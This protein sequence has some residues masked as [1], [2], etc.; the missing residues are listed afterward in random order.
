ML[1]PP[2]ATRA[3]LSAL[4]ALTA[5]ARAPPAA[6]AGVGAARTHKRLAF[7]FLQFLAVVATEADH[8]QANFF[9]TK[10]ELMPAVEFAGMFLRSTDAGVLRASFGFFAALLG[11]ARPLEAASQPSTGAS[12]DPPAPPPLP[13]LTHMVLKCKLLE[14]RLRS[15]LP[16]DPDGLEAAAGAGLGRLLRLLLW[17]LR[18]LAARQLPIAAELLLRKPMAT[19]KMFDR[20]TGEEGRAEKH[21]PDNRQAAIARRRARGEAGDDG[22]EDPTLRVVI[23]FVMAFE[24]LLVRPAVMPIPGLSPGQAMSMLEQCDISPLAINLRRRAGSVGG[25]ESDWSPE[26]RQV[27][28]RCLIGIYK[29]LRKMSRE[30]MRHMQTEASLKATKEEM[31]RRLPVSKRSPKPRKPVDDEEESTGEKPSRAAASGIFF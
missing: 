22:A 25:P 6:A 3:R 10:P 15:L 30:S 18:S 24:A 4:P 16:A 11:H 28:A 5:L 7:A 12:A 26:E 17:A 13:P 20:Y 21:I 1:A 19:V 14:P 29:A 27:V 23:A 8:E 9:A 2:E 31:Q